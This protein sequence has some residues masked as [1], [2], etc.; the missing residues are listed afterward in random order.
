MDGSLY[1]HKFGYGIQGKKVVKN[2][3]KIIITSLIMGVFIWYFKSLNLFIL[4][5]LAI[6]FY[7][8]MMYIIKGI[9]HEDMMIFKRIIKPREVTEK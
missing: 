4:I 1:P 6:L 5:I 7:L 2:I 3:S 9:T 8:I